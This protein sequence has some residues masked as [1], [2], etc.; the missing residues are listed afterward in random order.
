MEDPHEGL[1]AEK[2]SQ[3]DAQSDQ[4]FADDHPPAALGRG[5]GER[6]QK[7]RHI[8]EGIH[9]QDEDHG[10]RNDQLHS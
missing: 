6:G 8:A 1:T 9:D 7:Q 10:G 3:H 4:Q 2:E 5:M